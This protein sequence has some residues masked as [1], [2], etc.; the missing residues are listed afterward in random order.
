[1]TIRFAAAKS[2]NR[3]RMGAEDL[4]MVM[5]LPAND[6]AARHTTEPMMH[7]ALR[8]FADHGLA[9]AQHARMKAESAGEAGDEQSYKYWLEICRAL[10]RRM[11]KE[12]DKQAFG[13]RCINA[14]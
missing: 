4:L 11:A 9:A 8:H 7:S 2:S 12:L 10:D 3:N 6:N 5:A 14:K 13:K 1:M